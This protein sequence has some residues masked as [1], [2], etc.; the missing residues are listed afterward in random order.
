MQ[1]A[2]RLY[3]D[4]KSEEALK[5]FE[6]MLVRDT[7]FVDGKKYAG[8]V[9]LKLKKYDEAILYFSQLANYQLYANPGK[10][11]HALTL[12]KRNQAGDNQQAKVLLEQ[13]V[14]NDLEGSKDAKVILEKW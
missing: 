11:Y 4:G 6:S 12:L 9:S 7:S 3:N 5:Y 1:T 2:L 14:K 10:F 8:I 13:V